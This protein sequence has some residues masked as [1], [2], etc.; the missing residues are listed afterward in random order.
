MVSK[1]KAATASPAASSSTRSAKVKPYQEVI[2]V[3]ASPVT[4]PTETHDDN[5]ALQARPTPYQRLRELLADAGRVISSVEELQQHIQASGS[6]EHRITLRLKL[7]WISDHVHKDL[8]FVK[9]HFIDAASPEPLQDLLGLFRDQYDQNRDAV[10]SLLFT[11]TM[12]NV[13]SSSRELPTPD[14]IVTI[15]DC[16][17]L[18]LYRDKECQATVR[19]RDL[20]WQ[21]EE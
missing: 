9:L 20:S 2:T 16:S 11:A 15:T 21:R 8:A 10:N 12:W 14:T 5:Q 19:L 3:R 4:S 18:A 1:S 13:E 17:K 6:T 7:L